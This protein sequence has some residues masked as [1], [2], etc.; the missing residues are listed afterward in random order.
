MSVAF[1]KFLLKCLCIFSLTP[2]ML[3]KAILSA[4]AP[5]AENELCVDSCEKTP[6]EKSDVAASTIKRTVKLCFIN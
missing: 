4:E 6:D 1:L 3:A 5:D 2:F